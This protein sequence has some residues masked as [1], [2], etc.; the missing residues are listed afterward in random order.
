M[1]SWP[2]PPLMEIDPDMTYTVRMETYAG[3][4]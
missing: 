2:K 1:K 3:Y 4:N